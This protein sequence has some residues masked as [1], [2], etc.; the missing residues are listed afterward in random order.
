MA[1]TAKSA[2]ATVNPPNHPHSAPSNAG[3][4]FGIGL[5]L[6]LALIG[7]AF[8]ALMWRSY[9]R[10][11]EMHAWP[12][13]PCLILESDVEERPIDFGGPPEFRL[14]ILYGYEWQGVR[15]TGDRLS[16][17]GNPWTSK[18]DVIRSQ[19]ATF[20][21]GT[22][23]TCRVNPADP[24]FS[25]LKPDSK[26]PGYSIWFPALFIVGGLGIAIRAI[27]AGPPRPAARN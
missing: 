6:A 4:L 9:D 3:R 18:R 20:E 22:R 11:R 7:I 13:V 16:L 15:H 23:L 10:A 19:A 27:T 26:A 14:A 2:L 5:G 25:V 8:V 21:K 24:A 12:E 1:K 17:R